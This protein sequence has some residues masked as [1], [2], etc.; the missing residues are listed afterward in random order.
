MKNIL[1][2]LILLTGICASAEVQTQLADKVIVGAA[3][4]SDKTLEFNNGA[5]TANPKIKLNSASSKIQFSQ[6]GLAFKDLGAN[7]STYGINL[8]TNGGFENGSTDWT[9]SGMTFSVISAGANLLYE[10]KSGYIT[11]STTG[12]YLETSAYTVP[13]FMYGGRC[14]ARIS[15]LGGLGGNVG[16]SVFDSGGTS[17]TGG[18]IGV[19]PGNAGNKKDVFLYFTCPTSGSMKLRIT[20]T[21]SQTDVFLDEAFL[22]LPT[23][24]DSILPTIQRF[25]TMGAG[26]YN[27]PNGVKYIKVRMV[28]GGGGAA[29]TGT[30]SNTSGGTGGNTTFGT[31]LLTANGGAGGAIS[32]NI[33]GAGGTTTVNSPAIS[34]VSLAGGNGQSSSGTLAA[35]IMGP[36][37][38]VS[39]FGGAGAGD[40]GARAGVSA[41]ANSGSG[42][43]GSGSTATVVSGAAGGAGGYV[44]AIIKSP[45]AS[46]SFNV[47]ASGTPGG[48]GTS[49]FAGGAG[50]SGVIIV[51]E[52]Y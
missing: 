40:L 10:T 6:D 46:Y 22:G 52:Y 41:I 19:F 23:W 49:G 47:G 20:S 28:G 12:Q 24:S 5:R 25:N 14:L 2:L 32:T 31:S 21:A 16:L 33:G 51:E 4:S 45:S 43:G 26:T 42:G 48:S 17:V 35:N 15:Y 27:T 3:S 29:G 13:R 37:G 38:G 9:A 44:E 1:F 50:G 18:T 36:N 8:L 34:L 39:F 11:A 30:A 7:A